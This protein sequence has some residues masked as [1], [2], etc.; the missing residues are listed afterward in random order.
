MFLEWRYSLVRHRSIRISMDT[1]IEIKKIA[2]QLASYKA[3]PHVRIII[4]MWVINVRMLIIQHMLT[5]NGTNA[6]GAHMCTCSAARRRY[7]CIAIAL[8]KSMHNR[9]NNSMRNTDVDVQL[10]LS[11]HQPVPLYCTAPQSLCQL[12]A[13]LS[14]H[15]GTVQHYN[16]YRFGLA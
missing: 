15:H 7:S 8:K 12:G 10:H 16:V 9:H 3:I 14:Y 4:R 1:S 5:G 6:H 11:Y 2:L 13:P